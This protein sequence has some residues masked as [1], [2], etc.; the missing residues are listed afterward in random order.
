[1]PIIPCLPSGPLGIV[2]PL[3]LRCRLLEFISQGV[4]TVVDVNQA[5]GSRFVDN[6]D[7]RANLGVATACVALARLRP[8]LRG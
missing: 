8:A 7:I 6:T 5:T 2:F 3:R 1:M 4:L